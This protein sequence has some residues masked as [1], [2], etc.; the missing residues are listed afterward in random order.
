MNRVNGDG[1]KYIDGVYKAPTVASGARGHIQVAL[2][3]EEATPV[4]VQWQKKNLTY[5]KRPQSEEQS[6]DKFYHMATAALTGSNSRKMPRLRLERVKKRAEKQVTVGEALQHVG[7]EYYSSFYK[8]NRFKSS[9]ATLKKVAAH[10]RRSIKT[11]DFSKLIAV[12]SVVIL[13][14]IAALGSTLYSYAEYKSK[15][16]KALQEQQ[17]QSDAKWRELQASWDCINNK[18][19]QLQN[20]QAGTNQPEGEVTC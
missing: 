16:T 5:K 7:P 15:T 11:A 2:P 4:D 10:T 12:Q 3:L 18:W 19:N 8:E 14:L 17:A 9:V 13:V 6:H 20:T 1:V